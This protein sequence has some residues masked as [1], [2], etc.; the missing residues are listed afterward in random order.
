MTNLIVTIISIALIA[1][2]AVMGIYY[3]GVAYGNAQVNAIAS[4]IMNDATQLLVAERLWATNHN[5]PDISCMGTAG[6]SGTGIS[7]LINDK[8][9]STWPSLGGFVT[10]AAG[11]KGGPQPWIGA[12]GAAG[13][14]STGAYDLGCYSLNGSKGFFSRFLFAYQSKNY[15]AYAFAANIPYTAPCNTINTSSD[16][17]SANAANDPAVLIAGIINKTYGLSDK[18]MPVTALPNGLYVPNDSILVSP[19]IYDASGGVLQSSSGLAY[20]FDGIYTDNANQPLTNFCEST[21]QG[22]VCVFGPS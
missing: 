12:P 16:Y 7:A 9:L 18:N 3:G 21:Y 19:Q 14:V 4:T 20:D 10:N 1:I 17:T 2:A 15:V 8:E 11:T 13:T 22:I 5:C 6:T